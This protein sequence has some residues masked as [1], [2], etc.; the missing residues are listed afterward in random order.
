MQGRWLLT[1]QTAVIRSQWCWRLWVQPVAHCQLKVVVF[2]LTSKN[3]SNLYS[4]SVY[5][6]LVQR[7]VTFTSSHSCS[8][9]SLTLYKF[10][11]FEKV[12]WK[13]RVAQLNVT[14]PYLGVLNF[15]YAAT[16]VIVCT[17]QRVLG[18][19]GTLHRVKCE[20]KIKE[21]TGEWTAWEQWQFRL[22]HTFDVH[23]MFSCV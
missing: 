1:A 11:C 13:I 14:Q 21:K 16:G 15:Q 9:S 17:I 6:P 3:D 20:G 12:F 4:A 23:W 18:M 2:F 19:Q 7:N 5:I 8:P 10:K 22:K